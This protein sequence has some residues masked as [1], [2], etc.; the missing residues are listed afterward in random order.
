LMRFN[1]VNSWH[2]SAQTHQ[3]DDGL[4]VERCEREIIKVRDW[5]FL[6]SKGFSNGGVVGIWTQSY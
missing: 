1:I 5:I 2:G 4:S 3:T 6:V